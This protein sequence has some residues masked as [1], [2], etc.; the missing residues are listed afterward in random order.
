MKTKDERLQETRC[1]RNEAEEWMDK[2]SKAFSVQSNVVSLLE[3]ELGE[4]RQRLAV[5][6]DDYR[7]ASGLWL[8]YYQMVGQLER[9][10]GKN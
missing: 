3:K 7:I 9:E 2:A 10:G 4:A 1:K 6:Q 8:D 5:L